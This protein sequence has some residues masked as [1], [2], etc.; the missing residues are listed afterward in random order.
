MIELDD[1]IFC[2]EI[3]NVKDTFT[4][5]PHSEQGLHEIAM[6]SRLLEKSLGESKVHEYHLIFYLNG[7]L[8]NLALTNVMIFFVAR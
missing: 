7:V 1:E 8:M 5:N 6:T 2:M 4:Y 3:Y